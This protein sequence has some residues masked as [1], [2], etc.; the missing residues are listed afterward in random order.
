MMVYTL[1]MMVD[2]DCD[3]KYIRTAL[4]EAELL[5]SFLRFAHVNIISPSHSAQ[6]Q[7]HAVLREISRIMLR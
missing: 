7:S 4:E 3:E 6:R 1:S 2:K 5:S